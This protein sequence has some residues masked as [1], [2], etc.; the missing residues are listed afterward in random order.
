MFPIVIDDRRALHAA[1]A[2][3]SRVHGLTHG[4]YRYPARFSPDLVG[5]A[6]E[7][8]TTPHELILDPF[9]GGG[10]TA[11]EAL[12][13]GRRFAGID[14]NPL[15]LVLTRAKTSPLSNDDVVRLREW[16]TQRRT[17]AVAD[18]G[19]DERLRNAPLSL[20][21]ALAPF[22]SEAHLLPTL[23]LRDAASA[24]LLHTAQWAVDGRSEPCGPEAVVVQLGLATEMLVAGLR[25][26]SVE[27]G[28]HDTRPHEIPRRRVLYEGPSQA[29]TRSRVTNR[30]VGRVSLVVTSPPY[31]GVH[32]LYHR[33]QVRGRSETPMPY[34]LAGRTDGLGPKHYTLGGRSREGLGRYFDAIEE[35]WK[36]TRRLLRPGATVVQVLSF[37]D[38]ENQLPRYLHA[39][40][41]A[42][43][44]C[45]SDP[46]HPQWRDV[47][48]RRWYYRVKPERG[49]THEVL[50]LHRLRA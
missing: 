22:V 27:A 39:M 41:L 12:A 47:P 7:E 6:I 29:V 46:V 14:L 25:E 42:G 28:R 44:E 16:A 32:V 11:V 15:S 50:L 8:Y 2:S 36:A 49:N 38:P 20:V 21:T 10:T 23:R 48:N 24:I 34:W 1:H 26:L 18:V 17:A 45:D 40:E 3:R 31:P 33:W 9:V 35:A 19:A 43:Y 13:R 4:L 5:A 37:A 30:L